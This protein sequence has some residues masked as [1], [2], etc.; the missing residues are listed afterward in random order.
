MS[1]LAS[2]ITSGIVFK[3]AD[4]GRKWTNWLGPL[5]SLALLAGVLHEYSRFELRADSH[6]L[7]AGI[8]FWALF[9]LHYLATPLCEWLI[10]RR[11][12]RLPSA[13][14]AALLR[15][16]ITND[17]LLGYLGEVYFYAWSRQRAKL[18][19]SP[20]GA[21]KDVAILSAVLSNVLTL[22]LLPLAVALIGNLPPGVDPLALKLSVAAFLFTSFV[23]LVF[24]RRLLSLP[25]GELWF[26]T[27]VQMA[28]VGMGIALY[29]ALWHLLLPQVAIGWWIALA[30]LR[31]LVARLPFAPSRDVLFAAIAGFFV[32]RHSEI[33]ALLALFG[34]MTMLL[35]LVLGAVLSAT[36][37]LESSE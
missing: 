17:L 29:A 9:V 15:K 8:G 1:A 26:I 3:P 34:A 23:P 10:Y 5:I 13:G 6:L 24:R 25:V 14:I 18:N 37:L 22:A 35:H 20:F 11:L 33:A 19:A 2:S 21:I 12:W 32:G 31:Q 16:E 28:R 4:A 36:G 7:A 30:G 27:R